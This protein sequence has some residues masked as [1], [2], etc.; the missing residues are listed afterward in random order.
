MDSFQYLAILSSDL[1]LL[2]LNPG[3]FDDP[4]TGTILH[5]TF[6]PDENEIPEFEAIS[7]CWGDQ[8]QPDIITLAQEHHKIIESSVKNH[9]KLR[10]GKNLSA[11]LRALRSPHSKRILWCDS[12]CMNQSDL[13]ERSAQVQKMHHVYYHAVSVVIWL[14][15]ETS[16]STLA[17]DTVRSCADLVKNVTLDIGSGRPHIEFKDLQGFPRDGITLDVNQWRA[18]E[19]LLAL[20]WHRRLWTLQEATLAN[21]LTCIVMLGDEEMTWKQLVEGVTLGCLWNTSPSHAII[22]LAAYSHNLEV[23]MARFLGQDREK[24]YNWYGV[25]GSVQYFE[26]SDD[27]DRIFAVR[28]LVRQDVAESIEV[29]YT[30]SLKEIFTSVC[31]YDFMK[32]QNLDFMKFCNAAV[33]PSW[34][35]DLEKVWSGMELDS[36]AGG[37]SSPSVHLIEPHVLEVTG[38]VCDEICN[39]IVPLRRR[40]LA[41]SVQELRRRTMNALLSLVPAE[42]LQD[43]VILNQFILVLTYGQVRDYNIQKIDPPTVAS[44]HS[45]EDWR[46]KIRQWVNPDYVANADDAQDP[47]EKDE[48]YLNCLSTAG[49]MHGCTKSHRG[50]FISVPTESRKGDIVAVFL[51]LSSSIVLR[52]QAEKDT[53]LVI[54]PAYH[55]DFSA[56]QAFLGDDFC[57]WERLWYRDYLMYAFHKEGN[58][59][60][61][62][63]RLD[64]VPFNDGFM[65]VTLDSGRLLWGRE[66]HRDFSAKDPRMSE[67]ALRDRGVPLQKF[68]LL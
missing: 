53:Y 26:C 27:R 5:R 33:S 21:K 62:D 63:P 1:R 3:S 43:D 49:P 25:L 12:I 14:G 40:T 16:W 52:P 42:S 18:I 35:A 4:L 61:Q 20:D 13:G 57:G 30:K 6:L 10:I 31:L 60:L 19:K 68:K 37:N 29:D 32:Y 65:E 34:V 11:A 59:R 2:E 45:L 55:P 7:Y 66:G 47:W 9:G 64:D 58:L 24:E 39:D 48:A 54:G 41:D 56:A 67:S 36:N 28:G 44:V 8:S 23:V 46:R 15:P 22:D 38:M 17:M 50:T 51:G